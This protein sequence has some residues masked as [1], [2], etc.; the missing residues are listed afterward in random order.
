MSTT[1]K[2]GLWFHEI[3]L[4][5]LFDTGTVVA[6]SRGARALS[7]YPDARWVQL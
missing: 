6:Y 5:K 1:S 2:P 7:I 3:M 4:C